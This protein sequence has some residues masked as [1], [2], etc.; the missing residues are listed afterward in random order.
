MR[1]VPCPHPN[2]AG[3]LFEGYKG[4]GLHMQV[5]E[6]EEEEA[7]RVCENGWGVGWALS[8]GQQCC[9]CGGCVHDG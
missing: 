3:Q 8:Q 2:C 7:Q 4:L 6:A 5:H 9:H 1:F